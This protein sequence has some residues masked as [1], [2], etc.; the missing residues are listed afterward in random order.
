MK[1]TSISMP[2]PQLVEIASLNFASYNP[3]IM[4]EREMAALKASMLEHG[5]VLNLVV[6]RTGMVLIGGHQRVRAL[7]ELCK[8]RRW[9]VP[10]TA[11]AML[12][13]VDDATAKR[14]N[15]ALNRISGEFD[16]FK[17]G[18]L[19]A[20]MDAM[21]DE[22]VLALGFERENVD[23]LIRGTLPPDVQADEL[24]AGIGDLNGLGK[25]P[26]LTID[27]DSKDE[28]DEVKHA[29]AAMAKGERVRPGRVLVRLLKQ[30]SKVADAASKGSPEP[31]RRRKPV[32]DADD[33]EATA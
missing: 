12:L 32:D 4:P 9:A 3:R 23:E 1:Q 21:S 20:G 22:Q 31:K 14:M 15:V 8:D 11:W 25:V 7:R 24:T 26:T 29:L 6:Q 10:A 28:R 27:F 5:M 2:S 18:D 33:L 17:L 13:D 16:P 30:A 19:F